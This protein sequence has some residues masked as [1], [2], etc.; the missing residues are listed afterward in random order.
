MFEL[1]YSSISEEDPQR[2]DEYYTQATVG[3]HVMMQMV[4]L[5]QY[6]HCDLFDDED[7]FWDIFADLRKAG[8][9]FNPLNV[10]FMRM[11]IIK[12]VTVV[13]VTFYGDEG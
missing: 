2:V 9:K 5:S 3:H 12:N 6:G 11:E 10:H 7:V 8:H 13:T 4:G 1:S